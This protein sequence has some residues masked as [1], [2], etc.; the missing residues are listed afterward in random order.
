MRV[1]PQNTSNLARAI[2]VTQACSSGRIEG[3]KR[4]E[5]ERWRGFA[6][7]G[8]GDHCWTVPC[9]SMPI[10]CRNM[11]GLCHSVPFE[12]QMGFALGSDVS[13]RDH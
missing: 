7:D 11:G 13:P 10:P 2:V 8:R 4:A 5:S 9:R 6:A 3:R 12:M 1:Q